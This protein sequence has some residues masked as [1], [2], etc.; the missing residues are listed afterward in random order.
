MSRRSPNSSIATTSARC[1]ASRP[2]AWRCCRCSRRRPEGAY[3]PRSVVRVVA[4]YG[5]LPADRLVADVAGAVFLHGEVAAHP[6]RVDVARAV[7]VH[8]DIATHVLDA[9]PAGAVLL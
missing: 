9:D 3:R 1:C 2:S 6:T 5:D 7:R 4:R 8:G